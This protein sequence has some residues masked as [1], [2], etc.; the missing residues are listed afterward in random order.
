MRRIST[1]LV[2]LVVLGAAGFLG[3]RWLNN[4]GQAS[5]TGLQTVPVQRGN[6][7]ATV[8]AAGNIAVKAETAPAFRT[9]GR[10][11]AVHVQLGS[12]VE[13]GAVLME[14]DTTDLELEAAKARLSLA[15]AQAKLADLKAG[16][17]AAAVAAAQANL[18]SARENLAKVQAG[19]TQAQLAAAAADLKAAQDTYQRLLAGATPDEITVAAADLKKAELAVRDAQAAY[20]RVAWGSDVGTSPEA[21]ALQQATLDYEKALAD[22]RLTQQVTPADVEAAAA[23]TQR[24]QDELDRLRSSPT[25][26]ELAAAEAQ[27]VQ[28]ESE[29]ETLLAGPTAAELAIAEAEV[30]QA[31]LSLQQAERRLEDARLVAPFAGTVVA[32]NYRVGEDT[33]EDLPG[34]SLADL[35]ALRIEVPLAEIDVA[36]VAVG[37]AAELVIDAL[38]GVTL[39]GRVSYIS[40][41]ATITQGVVNYPVIVEIANPDPAVRPGMTAGVN[42]IVERRENVLLVPNRAVRAAGGQRVVEV[43]FQEQVFEAPVSLGISN[44]TST[45]VVGG[46]KEGDLVVLRTAAPTQ[47]PSN[48]GR[49]GFFGG[50]GGGGQH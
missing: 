14:L 22:Y 20:D 16:P 23:Q 30:D 44:E 13:A 10:V 45:E 5:A 31:R 50:F 11:K 40:P 43:L 32:V 7:V 21:Q 6:L 18:E 3:Y 9:T 47:A 39:A 33:N 26:A 1:L 28:A 48:V 27:V 49:G 35:S 25:A 38:P 34:V 12:R 4:P 46:L 41:V 29:L 42:I 8:S 17:T 19:P 15:T 24:A 37:Q 2:L 36:R